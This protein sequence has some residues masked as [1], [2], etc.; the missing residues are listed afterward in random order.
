MGY[1]YSDSQSSNLKNIKEE[2]ITKLISHNFGK[3]IEASS[4]ST[5]SLINSIGNQNFLNPK[6]LNI[7]FLAENTG[8]DSSISNSIEEPAMASGS[9]NFCLKEK[10]EEQCLLEWILSKGRVL[11]LNSRKERFSRKP[12]EERI[13][14][15]TDLFNDS[16]RKLR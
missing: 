8:I 14:R 6:K 2:D 16:F 7:L 12:I 13:F 5:Q 11:H 1:F 10:S 9:L 15:R 4:K 3:V